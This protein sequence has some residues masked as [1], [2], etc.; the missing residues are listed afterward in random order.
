MVESDFSSLGMWWVV[1]RT[2]QCLD[3]TVTMHFLHLVVVWIYNGMLP[4]T[5]SWWVVEA[6]GMVVT[7]VCAEFL[8]MRTEL[9]AIP[10]SLG[11]KADL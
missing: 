8:C 6:V 1:R 3:F 7:C 5:V 2:K 10:V 9:A 4:N 11:A